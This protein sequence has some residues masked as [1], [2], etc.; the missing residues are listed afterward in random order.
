M[1]FLENLN[2]R[3]ATKKFDGQKVP[4]QI[5]EK[6]LEAIRLTPSSFG[7]QP[8]RIV[9]V[10]GSESRERLNAHAFWD[11]EQIKT[12]S[13]LLIFCV[14]SNIRERANDYVALASSIGRQDI[15]DDPKFD[16]EKEAV[17]FG[18]KMGAEW[19]AKQLYIALGFALAACAELKV[20]SCPMEAANFTAIKQ[21]LALAEN[22]EPKVLLPI[23]YRSADDAHA[24][25][26]KV[27]FSKEDLFD[28]K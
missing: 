3:Y 10:E 27:R 16:Y 5:L 15:T 13:H 24:Q 9:V 20:D 21:V 6:I 1:S 7:I 12:C 26:K 4:E 23:G 18:E 17:E 14:D 22:L 19:T 2:W 28:L 11:Q 8:Y 25:D